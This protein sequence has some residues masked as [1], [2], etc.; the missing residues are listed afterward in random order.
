MKHRPA[1]NSMCLSDKDLLLLPGKAVN[2]VLLAPSRAGQPVVQTH[3]GHAQL[4]CQACTALH[5]TWQ[6]RKGRTSHASVKGLAT[7]GLPKIR[8]A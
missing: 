8:N 7:S 5:G 6:C 4:A 3:G 2:W 1:E